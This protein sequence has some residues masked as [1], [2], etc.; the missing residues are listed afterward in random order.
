[1]KIA[2]NKTDLR[3]R[4]TEKAIKNAFFIELRTKNLPDRNPFF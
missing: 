1:M 3:I 4:K 2:E